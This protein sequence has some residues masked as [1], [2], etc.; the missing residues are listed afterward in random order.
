MKKYWP[1][2][3]AALTS[4][5]AFLLPSVTAYVAHHPQVAAQVASVAVIV[6]HLMK[7]PTQP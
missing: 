7:S 6:A 3:L 4:L 2:I 5:S 1:S